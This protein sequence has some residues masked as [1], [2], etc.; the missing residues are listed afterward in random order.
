MWDV[1]ERQ[2]ALISEVMISLGCNAL[3][4]NVIIDSVLGL[5]SC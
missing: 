3:L 1:V 4:Y 5:A 2:A